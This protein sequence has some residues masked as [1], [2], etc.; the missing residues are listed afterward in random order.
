LRNADGRSGTTTPRARNAYRAQSASSVF[1]TQLLTTSFAIEAIAYRCVFTMRPSPFFSK[2]SIA[3]FLSLLP[4]ITAQSIGGGFFRNGSGAPGAAPY[5]LV[6]EYLPAAFF[7]NFD[8]FTGGDPTSGHV[9]YVDRA[10]ALQNGYTTTVNGAARMSVDTTNKFPLGGRGRPAVRLISNNSYTHGMFIAD[11]KHMP[12]GCGTWPAYWL[13]GPDPWP[14][15][16]EI[17]RLFSCLLMTGKTLTR[18]R[19]H[20]GCPR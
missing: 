5:Q 13:L 17:G 19:Y 18:S 2:T 11:V 1:C 20:R 12:T 10:T 7:D 8:F 9:Q 15:Y 14:T 16:G 4:L 3:S 6:D